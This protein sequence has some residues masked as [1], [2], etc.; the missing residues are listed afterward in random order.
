MSGSRSTYGASGRLVDPDGVMFDERGI[1]EQRVD[2]AHA[3]A[4]EPE[5][6]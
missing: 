6:L 1:R 2:V 5:I 3:P 4:Q